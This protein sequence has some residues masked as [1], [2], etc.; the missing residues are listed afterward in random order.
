MASGRKPRSI[1][2]FFVPRK[3][4]SVVVIDDEPTPC[5]PAPPKQDLLANRCGK[6]DTLEKRLNTLKRYKPEGDWRKFEKLTESFS[7]SEV[8]QMFEHVPSQRKVELWHFTPYGMCEYVAKQKK[9]A[10]ICSFVFNLSATT[11]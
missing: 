2:N 3:N 5:N 10:I 6:Y 9:I 8:V 4:S 1:Q 11:N 7:W